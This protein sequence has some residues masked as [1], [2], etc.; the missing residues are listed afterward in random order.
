MQNVV[1]I[2]LGEIG[3]PIYNLISCCH[4]V[5]G[6][7]LN[8]KIS[9]F[10]ADFNS[11]GPIDV[12]HFCTP[13]V[14]KKS[15]ETTTINYIKKFSPALVIIN[16]TITPGITREI[17]KI[18]NSAIVHSPILGVHARMKRDL[19]RY[20][21]HIGATS[22][23]YALLASEHFQSI[24]LKTK[25]CSS[26]EATEL[27]KLLETTYYG[28]L[29]AWAQETNRICKKFGCSYEE[30]SNFWEEVDQLIGGRPVMAPGFIGG[31][32]VIP[33]ALLLKEIL[34]SD[35]IDAILKSN[36]LRKKELENENN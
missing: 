11:P 3:G 12:M 27:M 9:N 36:D 14:D 21:K 24:G 17:Q 33:N 31:H 32:C 1:V 13:F 16:S 10:A 35:F 5:I 30:V 4:N 23:D 7:D 6:I 28:L 34:Q 26:P 19:L 18:T 22:V 2:G 20:T 29:I 15:F 8:K 25:I